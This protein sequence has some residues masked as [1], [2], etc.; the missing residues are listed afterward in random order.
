MIK[1]IKQRINKLDRWDKAYYTVAILISMIVI[2]I[3]ILNLTASMTNFHI[4]EFGE[5]LFRT[6]RFIEP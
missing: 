5:N 1:S 4:I 3:N 6:Y 2:T